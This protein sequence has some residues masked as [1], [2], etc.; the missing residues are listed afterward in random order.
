MYIVSLNEN[1]STCNVFSE[2]YATRNVKVFKRTGSWNDWMKI[3]SCRY[4][5]N[6]IVFYV[7]APKEGFYELP[8][9]YHDHWRVSINDTTRSYVR[10]KYG[11]IG[12]RLPKGEMK[13]SLKF[14]QTPIEKLSRDVSFLTLLIICLQVILPKLFI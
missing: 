4:E 1:V 6:K 10:G 3:T 5:R 14:I 13:V 12:V 9:Q 11:L 7:K 2:V 8:V